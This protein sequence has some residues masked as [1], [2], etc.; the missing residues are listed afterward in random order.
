MT[1]T[2]WIAFGFLALLIVF[3]IITVLIRDKL[4]A[5]QVNTLRFLTSVCAGFAGG[6]FT[7]DALFKMDAIF[8]NGARL[9]ISGTAGF[10]LFLTVWFTYKPVMGLATGFY[11][12]VLSGWTFEQTVLAI[13]EAN[14]SISEFIGFGKD[15][16]SL[17]LSERELN[18]DNAL[19]ALKRLR[20]LNTSLP[21]YS[22]SLND[23]VYQIEKK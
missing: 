1:A 18:T 15:E 22:V 19:D 13:M 8:S 20:Y 5:N 10:A 6:F 7:G 17:V 3:L 21:N 11:F 12:K 14:N 2:L 23:D 4:S 16:L 9:A